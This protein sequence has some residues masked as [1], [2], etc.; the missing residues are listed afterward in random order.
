MAR[1]Q[2]DPLGYYK[3]LNLSPGANEAEIRLAYTFLKNAW[4]RDRRIPRSR[5]KEAYDCL[6]DSRQKAAYDSGKRSRGDRDM[7]AVGVS[8]AIMVALLLFAGLIFPGFFLPN[9]KPFASGTAVV[10]QKDQA[11]LGEIVRR[12]PAHLFPNGV[13]GAAYLVRLADGTERWYPTTDLEN[14]YQRR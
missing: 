12:E 9:P 7:V 6:S 8:G 3:V 4:Q 14:H 1:T 5:I 11:P 13:S 2:R 10:R